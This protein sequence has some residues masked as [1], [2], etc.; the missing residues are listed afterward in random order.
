M[1]IVRF[2]HKGVE[3]FFSE[4][5]MAGIQSKHATRLRL[6]LGRLSVTRKPRDMGL[7]GARVA[8]A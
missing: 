3:R 5:L 1:G 8:S 7:P 2:K 4:G 6:I